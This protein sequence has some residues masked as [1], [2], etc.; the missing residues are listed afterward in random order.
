M[1]LILWG[2]PQ[3]HPWQEDVRP[4]RWETLL[5][6]IKIVYKEAADRE[7]DRIVFMGDL[8]EDKRRVRTDIFSAVFQE[9]LKGWN[10]YKIP[11]HM[12]MGNHDRWNWRSILDLFRHME[13]FTVYTM[14][15]VL[16]PPLL[17]V[18]YG[19]E[20]AEHLEY[21][22]MFAHS[23]ILG[24]DLG[25]GIRSV[26]SML[27]EK[28]LLKKGK[29]QVCFNGHYHH[30]QKIVLSDE[31]IPVVCVGTPA[32]LNWSD[33][34]SDTFRGITVVDILGGTKVVHQRIKLNF[35][36]FYNSPN[37]AAKKGDFVRNLEEQKAQIQTKTHNEHATIGGGN[38]ESAI[39]GYVSEK[40]TE[41][42]EKTLTD[43]GIHIYNAR[44][45]T[46]V[47]KRG[48]V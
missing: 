8:F 9:L 2:D 16:E 12:L 44:T 21:T 47:L 6:I 20:V 31:H 34:D 37:E 7:A 30:P 39:R 33:A 35:P 5:N 38:M 24:G 26:H 15:A 14:G 43:L 27:P 36:R 18:P 29:R 42:R 40:G 19:A 41:K 46:N 22:V 28:A 25:Q 32:E 48:G 23:E 17:F 10:K 13:G 1:K 3:F 4:D 11:H 45:G